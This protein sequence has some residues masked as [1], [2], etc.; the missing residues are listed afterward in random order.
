MLLDLTIA[1]PVKNEEANLP[2]CLASIGQDFVRKVVIIDS[3]STEIPKLLQN[4][5][6]RKSSN[7]IGMENFQKS[8]IG[9]FGIIPLKQ[10]GCCF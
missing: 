6:K 9:T 10:N 2:G 8:E 3:G 1:I 4:N 7:S 5:I